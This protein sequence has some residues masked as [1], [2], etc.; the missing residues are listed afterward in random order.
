MVSIEP[1]GGVFN[2]FGFVTL[3]GYPVPL[4]NIDVYDNRMSTNFLGKDFSVV[5]GF[6]HGQ[7]Y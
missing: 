3:E 5:E 7:V 6:Y 4:C 2:K 1:F